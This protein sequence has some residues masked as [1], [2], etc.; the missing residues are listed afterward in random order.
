MLVLILLIIDFTLSLIFCLNKTK[1]SDRIVEFI[2]FYFIFFIIG[3]FILIIIGNLV[4]SGTAN[5]KMV[6]T[7]KSIVSFIDSK[8]NPV[9]V[10]YSFNQNGRSVY[11]Y[12][13]YNGKYPEYKEIFKNK[14]VNIV[15]GNYD[16]MLIIHSYKANET[17][18]TLFDIT[19]NW[20]THDTWYEFYIPD[21]TFI[22]Y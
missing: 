14:D 18:D 22:T 17:C 2:L 15:E 5:Q 9:Y 13:E 6:T 1:M 3:T 19:A 10:K 16:P 4:F 8:D 21:G 7:K 20:F 11:R 12:I